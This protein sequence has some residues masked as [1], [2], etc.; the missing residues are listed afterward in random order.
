M[1]LDGVVESSKRG[2][3]ELVECLDLR[4]VKLVKLS[5]HRTVE[6]WNVE[7]DGVGE[8]SSC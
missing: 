4:I 3:M 7:I 1:E 8:S 2:M 5:N 6:W